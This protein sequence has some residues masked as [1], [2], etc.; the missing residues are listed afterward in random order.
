MLYNV[1]VYQPCCA[2]YLIKI[3]N[4]SCWFP[5]NLPCRFPNMS[6]WFP[7]LSCQ[8]PFSIPFSPLMTPLFAGLGIF[9][10]DWW[11]LKIFKPFIYF[12][13]IFKP[14]FFTFL[15]I[16]IHFARLQ[17]FILKI[18]KNRWSWRW[19]W[20]CLH[21]EGIMKNRSRDGF[22]KKSIWR[23]VQP[24]I[25]DV[26]GRKMIARGLLLGHIISTLSFDGSN[27]KWINIRTDERT[28]NGTHGLFNDDGLS[29]LKLLCEGV[30][31]GK[32]ELKVVGNLFVHISSTSRG[33]RDVRR[34][35]HCL[36]MW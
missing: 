26:S 5:L 6:C 9:G 22:K 20:S 24:Q 17:W 21:W 28:E 2:S 23:V 13:K 25:I 7:N 14:F 16:N 30:A 8:F 29:L 15:I 19:S 33:N 31:G 1:H 34:K 4:P 18:F 12:Q 35:F 11:L 32:T 3:R 36:V 27:V 10:L